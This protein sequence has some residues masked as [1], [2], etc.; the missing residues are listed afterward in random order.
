MAEMDLTEQVVS[1]IPDDR[2]KIMDGLLEKLDGS[3]NCRL[4]LALV[5]GASKRERQMV[6]LLVRELDQFDIEQDR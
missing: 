3:E 1:R 4:L 2:R 5:A 6:R